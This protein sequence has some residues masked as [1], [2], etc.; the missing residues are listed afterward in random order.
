MDW[1]LPPLSL[2]N[3][4]SLACFTRY[5]A[6][7]V[8]LQFICFFIIWCF[9]PWFHG[10]VFPFVSFGSMASSLS[11]VIVLYLWSK[12]PLY[13]NS[14]QLLDALVFW[15]LFVLLTTVPWFLVVFVDVYTRNLRYWVLFPWLSKW[16]WSFM[17]T[18]CGIYGTNVLWNP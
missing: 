6:S 15:L 8:P 3:S 10:L 7:L 17:S 14:V 4:W 11:S 1:S 5:P 12:G 2:L 9:V 18:V 13:L 16:L